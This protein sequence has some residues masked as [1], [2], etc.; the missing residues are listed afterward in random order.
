MVKGIRIV[1]NL[2]NIVV[3]VSCDLLFI[4]SSI[5]F[6]I[7]TFQGLAECKS[8]MCHTLPAWQIPKAPVF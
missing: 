6:K 4:T 3:L 7:M 5:V 1:A 2:Y 8:A